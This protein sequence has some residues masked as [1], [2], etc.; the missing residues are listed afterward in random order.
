MSLWNSLVESLQQSG[1]DDRAIFT[2]L[3]SGVGALTFYATVGFY[4]FIVPYLPGSSSWKIDHGAIKPS[5]ELIRSAFWKSLSTFLIANPIL[6]W[7]T[8]PYAVNAF[9]IF[10][11]GPMPSISIVIWQLFV[12]ALLEDFS[13][14]W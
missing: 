4:S 10:M 3:I 6:T 11:N 12:C 1:F 14:Y 9:G 13:F 5:D 7:L 2:L 8:F